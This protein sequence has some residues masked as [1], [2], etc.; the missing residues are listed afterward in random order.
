MSYSL[1]PL[2]GLKQKYDLGFKIKSYFPHGSTLLSP[3]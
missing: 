2:K 3:S 1:D